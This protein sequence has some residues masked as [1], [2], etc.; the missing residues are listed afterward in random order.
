DYGPVPVPHAGQTV[1]LTDETW[2]LYETAIRRYEGRAARRLGDGTF[3][4]DGAP[5]DRYT[6]TQDYYFG[7]GDNRDNSED[8]RFWG[9]IPEDHLI[10]KAVATFFSWDDEAHRP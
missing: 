2:P 9:F 7:M 4:I 6:F 1:P 3:E 10:G 5:T 8:S